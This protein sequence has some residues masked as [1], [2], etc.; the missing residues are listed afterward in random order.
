MTLKGILRKH[1]C[2]TTMKPNTKNDATEQTG[3][4]KVVIDYPDD[5]KVNVRDESVLTDEGRRALKNG[6]LEVTTP[7]PSD[8]RRSHG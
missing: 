5:L 6:V 3:A 8:R 4:Y 7:S 2:P 1:G